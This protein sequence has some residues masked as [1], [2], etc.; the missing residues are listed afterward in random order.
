MS[1]TP[2]GGPCPEESAP[3]AEGLDLKPK[4]RI[5]F[6]TPFFSFTRR[7]F[8]QLKLNPNAG[9]D[10]S[11]GRSGQFT[12]GDPF[13]WT[14]TGF[15]MAGCAA[16]DHASVSVW[17]GGDIEIGYPF[18]KGQSKSRVPFYKHARI[19]RRECIEVIFSQRGPCP[20]SITVCNAG[21]DRHKLCIQV[22]HGR[23]QF[24]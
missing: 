19:G 3:E 8:Q 15:L 21:A 18:V 9:G 17:A 11:N 14:G 12:L 1:R 23:R 7:P 22:P 4:V 20:V 16:R 24:R 5:S 2:S 6:F 10:P 13:E